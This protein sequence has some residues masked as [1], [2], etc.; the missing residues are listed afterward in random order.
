M[1]GAAPMPTP[2][3]APRVPLDFPPLTTADIA[4]IVQQICLHMHDLREPHLS[5]CL[6]IFVRLPG[7]RPPP[8]MLRL[9][10]RVDGLHRCGLGELPGYTPVHLVLRCVPQRQPRLLII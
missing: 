1:G 5:A 9:L 3:S 4:Y 2:L 10:L 8:V 6:T 7:L